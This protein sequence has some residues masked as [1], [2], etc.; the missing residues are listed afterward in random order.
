MGTLGTNWFMQCTMTKNGQT[1]LTN[2]MVF[3]FKVLFSIF[4][5]MHESVDGLKIERT[6]L[7]EDIQNN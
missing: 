5:I 7:K 2:L 4:Y 3:I 1:Y 6:L